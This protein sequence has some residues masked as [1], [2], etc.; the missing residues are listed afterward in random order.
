MAIDFRRT[1]IS[2]DPTRGREQR[3]SGAVVFPS[4]VRRAEAAINGF[5]VTYNNGDHHV[6]A[7][8]IDIDLPRIIGNTVFVDVTFLL[9]DSSGSIDDPFSGYVDVTVIVERI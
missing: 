6:L 8:K 2:F 4:Q 5:Y 1:R 7:Q 3:E 9:R